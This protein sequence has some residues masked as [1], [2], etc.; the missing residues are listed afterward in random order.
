MIEQLWKWGSDKKR[1][2]EIENLESNGL[3]KTFKTAHTREQILS[4]PLE[5]THTIT[6][7]EKKSWINSHLG[8][9]FNKDK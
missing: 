1:Q 7:K 5:N 8:M 2:K 4:M 6:R 3:L 9:V